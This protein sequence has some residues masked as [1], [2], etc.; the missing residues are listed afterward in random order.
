MDTSNFI[1][2]VALEVIVATHSR[3]LVWDRNSQPR[4]SIQV[5]SAIAARCDRMYAI[6]KGIV[7]LSGFSNGRLNVPEIRFPEMLMDPELPL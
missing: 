2:Y 4:D 7:A 1:N 5:A 6:D 3:N